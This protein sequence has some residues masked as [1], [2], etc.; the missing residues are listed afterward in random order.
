MD[1]FGTGYSSLSYLQSF[2][3]DKIKID[4]SFI[5]GL[6]GNAQCAAIVRAAIGL[7]HGLNLPVI[8]EGVE[9]E[10]QMEF[11]R[12]EKCDEV[13]GHFIGMPRPIADYADLLANPEQAL[14]V[15]ALKKDQPR[16]TA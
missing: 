1:D 15:A 13:Q 4:S 3:F 8:A 5:S 16:R 6:D 12:R 2:P 14:P 10:S 11:L 7:G 9:T